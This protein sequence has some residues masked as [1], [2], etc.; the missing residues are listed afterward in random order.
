VRDG[1]FRAGFTREGFVVAKKKRGIYADPSGTLQANLEDKVADFSYQNDAL[2]DLIVDVW[3]NNPTYNNLITGSWTQRS[4]A[5]KQVLAARGI[6]LDQAIV[7]KETEY[8][9]GFSLRDAGLDADKGVVFVLPRKARA[10]I[11]PGTPLLET[12]KMLMAIT[13]HGI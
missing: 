12:A 13:P 5:A 11:A 6:Y 8:E 3:L 10:A 9:D 4:A 1:K 7:I 2:A